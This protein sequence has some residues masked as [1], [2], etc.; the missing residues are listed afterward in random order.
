MRKLF[1][2][3]LCAAIIAGSLTLFVACDTDEK[4]LREVDMSLRSDTLYGLYW[5]GDEPG[6]TMK[7][8][9]NMPVEY[10]DPEKPTLIYSH[11]WKTSG[12]AKEEFSTLDKT[13][14]KT[15]GTSGDLDYAT[16]LKELG[17]NVAFFDWYEYAHELNYLQNEIWVVKSTDSVK[18][19]KSNYYAAV[20][21]LNGRSFAGEIVRSM[22][23]VMKD[24]TDKDVIFVGHSF[25]GQMVTAAA[26]TL[27]KLA[28]EGII[29]NKNILPDRISLA[30][31]YMPG[32]EVSGKMDLLEETVTSQPTAQ[33]AADAFEYMNSKGVV[34]DLNGAMQGWTYDGYKALTKIEDETLRAQ[35]DEKIKSNTVYIIQKALTDAYG[36]LGDIHV[37]SRDYVLTSFIEGKKGNLTNCVPNVAM[38]AEQLREYVGRQFLLTGNGFAIEDAAM[39]E[40]LE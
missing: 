5:Y 29:T 27:Y 35:V 38:S 24:A 37:I 16:E 22:Y 4:N 39:T 28:D 6:D 26:Y 14:S 1:A 11:G 30:D 9:E 40:V 2:S 17:Y 13:F 23:A 25:G 31:P 15:G 7:S 32:T 33:K 21:A 10:Y 19:E 20:V 34:I 12:E 3:L 8:Q 18:D 36:K